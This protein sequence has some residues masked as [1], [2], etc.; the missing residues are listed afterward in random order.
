MAYEF[1]LPDIG[2]G[3][4]E[5][6]IVKWMVEE[7]QEVR[8]D[9]ILAEVQTDKAVVE[10]PSPVSGR[11]LSLN[12]KEGE[13]VTV[14]T[15]IATFAAE[16][17][18]DAAPQTAAEHSNNDVE[19]KV[20]ENAVG[21]SLAD[22]ETVKQTAEKRETAV[23]TNN[24]S[25]GIK[26]VLATPSVR[27][28]AR[29]KG[30]DITLIKGTGNHGQVLRE[31]IDAFLRQGAAETPVES[32]E[33]VA[34]HVETAPADT[35]QTA[36]GTEPVKEKRVPLKGIRKKIAQSMVKSKYT[37]P[38]VTVMDEVDVSALV[39]F[40]NRVKAKGEQ[41]G[42]KLTYLPFVVKA[43]IAAARRFPELN[44]SLDDE[45]QE[46]VYKYDYNI[47]IAAATEQGLLVP[48]VKHADQKSIW[49][50]ADEINRL[51]DKARERK[52]TLE[53]MRGGTISIS[54][55]GSAG[56]MFFTPVINHPEVAILGVGQIVQKPVVK[57][58]ALAIGWVMA[59]SLSFDHRVID[60]E[61][62]QRALNEIKAL[63][64]DPEDLLLEV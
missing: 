27:K 53:E 51:A 49:K 13:V 61:L 11:V 39:E 2:E 26:E 58:G 37:A 25:R 7:G 5:G 18:A 48:V 22:K 31:D 47:G 35:V 43:L 9:D 40:R 29:E 57:D 42:I 59:L 23:N 4:H 8:E 62:A 10:I 36:E 64:A 30:A 56:G 54:N 38:H 19:F 45:A 60:G 34:D 44:A 24:I 32:P 41:K 33:A 52:L 21:E 12:A 63:L 14:G 50:I 16:G 3:I 28:Y 6:E 20:A 1:K 55:I 46:I 15:V 17:E